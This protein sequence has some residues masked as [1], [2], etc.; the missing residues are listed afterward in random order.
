MCVFSTGLPL[1]S[2]TNSVHFF[3]QGTTSAPTHTPI[4]TENQNVGNSIGK[5]NSNYGKHW[6]NIVLIYSH[7]QSTLDFVDTFMYLTYT[8][9]SLLAIINSILKIRF[10]LRSISTGSE[11]TKYQPTIDTLWRTRECVICVL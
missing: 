9:R 7:G 8:F 3:S 5:Y 11:P 6:V 4:R 2:W 1:I 10:W